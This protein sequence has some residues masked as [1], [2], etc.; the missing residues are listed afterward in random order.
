M[1]F[2]NRFTNTN[3][4]W[5]TKDLNSD[6]AFRIPHFEFVEPLVGWKFSLDVY[7]DRKLDNVLMQLWGESRFSLQLFGIR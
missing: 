6:C 1:K 4:L 3:F 5:K 7:E 2:S